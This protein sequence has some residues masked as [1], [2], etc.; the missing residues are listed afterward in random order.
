MPRVGKQVANLVLPQPVLGWE[1]CPGDSI[2]INNGKSGHLV[3]KV[4]MILKV[5]KVVIGISDINIEE[6]HGGLNSIKF[7]IQITLGHIN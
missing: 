6:N 2:S 1:P 7:T 3:T 4:L 5:E